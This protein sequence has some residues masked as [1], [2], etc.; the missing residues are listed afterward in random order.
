M[1]TARPRGTAVRSDL[2]GCK[3][4]RSSV[5][6]DPLSQLLDNS[7]HSAPPSSSIFTSSNLYNFDFLLFHSS[8]DLVHL[9]PLSISIILSYFPFSPPSLCFLSVPNIAFLP[10]QSLPRPRTLVCCVRIS[11]SI[12]N[13][14]MRRKMQYR[15]VA[16]IHRCV[17]EDTVMPAES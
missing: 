7:H 14:I 11:R 8:P 12:Q 6:S 16:F 17:H 13:Y 3:K 1:V 4:G 9:P 5:L 15:D 2:I 10:L